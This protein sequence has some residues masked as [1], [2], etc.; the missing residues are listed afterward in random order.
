MG[1]RPNVGL[2]A[3]FLSDLSDLSD[4]RQRHL[5]DSGRAGDQ[6]YPK[7]EAGAAG[8]VHYRRA[9]TQSAGETLT[10]TRRMYRAVAVEPAVWKNCKPRSELHGEGT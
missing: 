3:A 9:A 8:A 5:C 10:Y 2:D 7:R 4:Y 6:N 1:R